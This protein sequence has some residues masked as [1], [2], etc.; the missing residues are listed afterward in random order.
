MKAPRIVSGF[1][2]VQARLRAQPS[3]V[4][5]ILLDESRNDARARE[6]V[7]LAQRCNAKLLRVQGKRLEG[8]AGRESG[9][10]PRGS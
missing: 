8:F 3:S 2:A 5:E 4:I 9:C 1:H 6:L 7:T 10:R